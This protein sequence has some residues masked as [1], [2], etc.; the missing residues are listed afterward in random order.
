MYLTYRSLTFRVGYRTD[1]PVIQLHVSSCFHWWYKWH[2]LCATRMRTSARAHYLKFVRKLTQVDASFFTIWPPNTSRHTLV[3]S[4]HTW[5]VR[6]L[7]LAWTCDLTCESVWPPIASL[8][9][10]LI[11][12]TCESIWSAA[13]SPITQFACVFLRARV[14][15]EWTLINPFHWHVFFCSNQIQHLQHD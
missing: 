10:V 5:N 9:Q 13:Y 15:K 2:S 4:E 12:Q 7:K 3:T 1:C 14:T 11:L 6:L 8:L